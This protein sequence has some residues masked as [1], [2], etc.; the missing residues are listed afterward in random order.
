[1]QVGITLKEPQILSTAL[2]LSVSLKEIFQSCIIIF[3]FSLDSN[4]QGGV[5]VLTILF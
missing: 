3:N 2:A 1:M 5:V 4:Q